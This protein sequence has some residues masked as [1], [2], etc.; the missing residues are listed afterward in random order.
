MKP[1]KMKSIVM[2]IAE[3]IMALYEEENETSPAEIA[4]MDITK[5]IEDGN[6][7]IESWKE[8]EGPRPAN[9]RVFAICL[10]RK[11]N[12]EWINL[13]L[14]FFTCKCTATYF[15]W[16]N[17]IDSPMHYTDANRFGDDFKQNLIEISPEFQKEISSNEQLRAVIEKHVVSNAG[18]ESESIMKKLFDALEKPDIAKTNNKAAE[19]LKARNKAKAHDDQIRTYG[20]ELQKKLGRKYSWYREYYRKYGPA[21]DDDYAGSGETTLG[22]IAVAL[23]CKTEKEVDELAD[24]LHKE[25]ISRIDGSYRISYGE[26]K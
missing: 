11:E 5:A 7:T 16:K 10:Y 20:D 26:K 24:R 3:S 14:F 1:E 9:A 2:K 17:K 12:D 23:G 4:D 19:N 15:R 13:N 8:D 21:H 22:G 25:G 18:D 6:Y